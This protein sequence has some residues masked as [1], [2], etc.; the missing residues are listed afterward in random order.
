MQDFLVIRGGR[1]HNL[2]NV[3]LDI[4]RRKLVVLSGLSGSGKSSL[5]FDTIYAEGQRRYVESLSAYARQFLGLMEK[6][7]VDLI[8]GLSP[9]ISIDQRSAA[10]GQ[11]STVGT[12]TEIYDY[13]RVLFAR[14][15]E[16]HCPVCHRLIAR[17][18][19]Q[20]I[21]DSVLELAPQTKI[22]ILA[23]KVKS[24]KGEHKHIFA[25]AKKAGFLRMRVNGTI[26][27]IDEILDLDKQKK[28]NIEIVVDRLVMAVKESREFSE[29]RGRLFESLETALKWGEGLVIVHNV[30]KEEDLLFSEQLACPLGHISLPEISPRCFSFNSP[31]GACPLCTGLGTRL[32]VDPALVLPNK[33][34]T[35]A[36]GAIRPW[37]KAHQTWQQAT[38]A[39]VARQKGFSL[40]V[41]VS[42]LSKKAL[43]IVLYGCEEVFEIRGYSTPFEGVIPNLERRYH[44]TDS[45]YLRKEISR[46][47]TIQP[48]PSCKGKR[49]K[50]A[51]LNVLVAG[52]SM[53]AVVNL[54]VLELKDWV[55]NLKLEETREIIARRLLKEIASRVDFLLKVGLD[56]LTLDRAAPS[57]SGGEA[58]RIRLA[59][60]V[61]S[62]LTGVLYILDEPTIGLHPRDDDRLIEILRNL[63]DLDNSVLVVEHDEQMLKSADFLIDVGPGAG[64]RGGHIVATGTPEEVMKN[65]D[66]LTGA[67]L[68]GRE[69]IDLPNARRASNSKY[70]EIKKAAEFNLKNIN[71]KIPLG[72][73]VVVSGVSGSGKSTLISEILA[74]ALAAKFYRSQEAPGKHEA[75]LGTEHIDK[76][77]SIDQ[78]PIGR[79][80]R[81]N[82]ATYTGVFTP[83]RE[84]FSLTLEARSR[85][86]KMGRFSF[87]VRGGRCENCKGEGVIK[88][89]MHFLPDVYVTCDEC[90]GTRYNR[91]AREVIYKGKNIAEILNMTVGEA[92]EFF[93]AIPVVAEKLKVLQEVG[94]GYIKLGQPATTLSGGEAQR[95]KLAS[96]LSRRSTGKTLY[97]LDEPTTG[98]HFEDVKK[99]LGVLNK[100]VDK[101]NTVLV[102]EHNL[103]VIKCADWVIDLGPEG[104]DLGGYLVDAGTPEKLATN[105]NSYTGQYLRKVL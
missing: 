8:D 41:P 52:K 88:I 5:A 26:L 79:T 50:P 29:E 84:I 62:R 87:N 12:I 28:H 36:E 70:L 46:Y 53:A 7:D 99:L 66:S 80:P 24:Q 68:A 21:T 91:E 59:T 93:Q 65:P 96:E 31:Y 76:V 75:I 55:L 47:M 71:V 57:L 48:C 33:T 39:E 27:S 2:K 45:D 40:N 56:Y 103:H 81:S 51:F 20:Q 3:D 23:P 11:R 92:L 102:I 89:E 63:R 22:I 83:I 15:G 67:Y 82:P 44:E 42:K 105:S 100:L 85:G 38:L 101:G 69:K 58:Q 74:K 49:L 43:D 64:E 30:D 9:A 104:G 4:P 6:P 19:I 35:L 72:L 34:L 90:K 54:S 78:S 32:V 10:G 25:E 94:L 18:T 98:L 37:T 61:G 17:Q 77:I 13:L 14:A 1:E 16:A 60:Q 95:I 73:F 97:I 86:Y